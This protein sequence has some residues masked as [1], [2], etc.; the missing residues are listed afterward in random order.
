MPSD[1]TLHSQ[2]RQSVSARH[3]KT[4][5]PAWLGTAYWLV[6]IYI[7]QL[8][9]YIYQ[10]SIDQYIYI[11]IYQLSIYIYQ[12][13]IDQLSPSLCRG[14]SARLHSARTRQD[15]RYH[16][17]P[18][19]LSNAP[20]T[21]LKDSLSRMPLTIRAV[22]V[23]PHHPPAAA[24]P[25]AAPLLR[26]APPRSCRAISRSSRASSSSSSARSAHTSCL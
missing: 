15:R 22:T 26:P 14:T 19:W 5:S 23:P 3:M 6:G 10:L 11:Y 20:P 12:L 8:S 4:P 13:S 24:A 18:K 25:V 17:T 2:M 21:N 9:I 16:A 7:Y 1:K